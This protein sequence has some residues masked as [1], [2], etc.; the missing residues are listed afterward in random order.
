MFFLAKVFCS[1]ATPSSQSKHIQSAFKVGIFASFLSS[2][3]GTYLNKF[4]SNTVKLY[5][6]RAEFK[7]LIQLGPSRYNSE[8]YAYIKARR[9]RY[10]RRCFSTLI[11]GIRGGSA[12]QVE[13]TPRCLVFTIFSFPDNLFNCKTFRSA[14]LDICRVVN[15][16]A[17][18]LP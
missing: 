14:L 16:L 8:I 5:L 10:G 6:G 4:I 12:W 9:G 13:V 17:Q 11:P 2:F 15:A 3:P 18:F 7:N 1:S